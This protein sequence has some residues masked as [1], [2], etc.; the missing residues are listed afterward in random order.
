M[1]PVRI[2]DAVMPMMVAGLMDG[3]VREAILRF[4]IRKIDRSPAG[5]A[6]WDGRTI[7][8]RE[9]G[10]ETRFT[11]ALQRC[12]D[13]ENAREQCRLNEAGVSGK[14]RDD[15]ATTFCARI[16]CLNPTQRKKIRTR[17]S[18]TIS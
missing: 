5:Y 9:E 10:V 6:R 14:M 11:P 17:I 18:D 16:I 4:V 3:C 15:E 13:E 7:S 12:D 1:T 8:R 2:V